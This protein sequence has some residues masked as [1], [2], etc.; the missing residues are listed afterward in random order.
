MSSEG[1]PGRRAAYCGLGKT[2]SDSLPGR[3]V[4][5]GQREDADSSGEGFVYIQSCWCVTF[6]VTSILTKKMIQNRP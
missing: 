4:A 6:L 2:L 3:K 1:P 5:R